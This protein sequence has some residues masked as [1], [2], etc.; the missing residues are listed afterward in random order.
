MVTQVA[1]SFLLLVGALLFVRTLQ[2]LAK[3]D[4]G[5]QQG[6]LLVSQVDL[7]HLQIPLSRRLAFKQK[8]LARLRATPGI[9]SAAQAIV[10]VS[11]DGW[12]ENVNAE[13]AAA[14]RRISN[15]NR[16]SPQ[17][18][19]T[20]GTPLLAGRDF[21]D[22]DTT[23]SPQV[24]IVNQTFAR[25]VLGRPNPVGST[26]GVVQEGGKPDERYEIVVLV[27]DT[28][29][30]DLRE[31]FTPIVFLAE[32]QDRHPGLEAQFVVRS[33]EPLLESTRSV[34]QNLVDANSP[35]SSLCFKTI[36]SNNLFE[37]SAREVSV[38]Q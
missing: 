32:S 38:S 23:S 30:N 15:F 22:G 37:P 31:E 28:K 36:A 17:F 8:L 3:L 5:F 12:N 7:S 33:N 11:G 13:G 21:K 16:I 26:F 34:H 4:A 1:L 25:K 19:Q 27:K 24:A 9:D 18:F 2:N 6:N 29:Y 35:G 20:M 10:P 14:Q